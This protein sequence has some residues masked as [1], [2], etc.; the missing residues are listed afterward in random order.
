MPFKPEAGQFYRMP[1]FFGP[2]PGPRQWPQGR[3]FDFRETPRMKMIG[4]RMLTNADQ[5]KAML[6]DRFELRGPPVITVEAN[7]MTEIGWL[8]GRGYNL[9]D[10]KFEVTFHGKDGPVNG[11]LVLVRF[12]NLADPILS[13]REELGHNKIYCE[14]PEPRLLDGRRS[15]RLGW[16]ETPFLDMAVW[17]L[18]PL[19]EGAGPPFEPDHQGMLSY[20]YIP[21]TGDWGTADVE[22]VTLSPHTELRKNLS[23]N[24][25]QVGKG[26]FAFRR[27]TWEELPTLYHIVNAFAELENHGFQGAH[28]IETIGGSSLA[29]TRRID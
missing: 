22:Y 19:P 12:E 11:T 4:V 17:D 10:V 24:S 9:C 16:M 3:D 6:P 1:I 27:A 29:E 5:L 21:A 15:T 7:Y 23:I 13:G 28:M 26:E 2:A 25:L 8:A 20:K 14:I 18:G